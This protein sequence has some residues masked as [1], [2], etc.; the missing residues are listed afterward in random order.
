MSCS[1]NLKLHYVLS[2]LL[3]SVENI[4]AETTTKSDLV[5]AAEPGGVEVLSALSADAK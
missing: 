3:A 1:R 5:V 2:D 4:K